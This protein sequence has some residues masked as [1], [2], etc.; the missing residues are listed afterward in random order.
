MKTIISG[1]RTISEKLA[2]RVLTAIFPQLDFRPSLIISGGASGVDTGASQYAQ[3]NNIPFQL[4]PALWNLHGKSAGALRNI[5]MAQNGE[6][7]LAVWDGE[8]KG[9][10]HMIKVAK[11]YNLSIHIAYTLPDRKRS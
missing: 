4:Y 10:E 8:S 7:L 3:E 6:F 11:D 1:S 2:K 5:E 9:T